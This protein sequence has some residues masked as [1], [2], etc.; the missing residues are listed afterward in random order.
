MAPVNN[1]V[2]VAVC[3]VSTDVELAEKAASF[4]VSSLP[5]KTREQIVQEL[6]SR[7]Q[8]EKKSRELQGLNHWEEYAPQY[9][10]RIVKRHDA[11]RRAAIA[12]FI[13]ARHEEALQYAHRI[14]ANQDLAERVLGQTY[15]E[16]LEGKTTLPYF[17]RALKLNAR[18]AMTLLS[19]ER[20][21]FESL[22]SS[23]MG[24]RRD[25]G[26]SEMDEESF[27]SPHAEDQD[28]LEILI[29]REEAATVQR[30]IY[31]ARQIAE[32]DRRFW[33]IRQQK[34]ARELKIGA[35]RSA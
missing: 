23:Q 16:L 27:T 35:S 19:I 12:T 24:V 34:W 1:A 33:W 26:D 25:G 4:L 5:Q 13:A 22:E 10:D 30:E 6:L 2:I 17:F 11:K 32:T 7:L 9:L 28:P 14:T 15:V 8:Q 20:R 3:P 21:H 31:E 29:Q 18:N